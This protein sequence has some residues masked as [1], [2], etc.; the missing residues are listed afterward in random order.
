V[1]PDEFFDEHPE[2]FS[3]IGGVRVARM[4]LRPVLPSQWLRDHRQPDPL[5]RGDCLLIAGL[6]EGEH[7]YDQ[8]TPDGRWS[9]TGT[10]GL[11]LTQTFDST[12]ID[13]TWLYAYP[14]TL[15]ELEVEVWARRE[16]LGPGESVVLRHSLEIGPAN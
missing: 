2:Y 16:V 3:E 8:N 13:F 4:P 1:S 7:Y 10:K 14:E 6:R 9:F 5:A 15:G 12:N 11:E